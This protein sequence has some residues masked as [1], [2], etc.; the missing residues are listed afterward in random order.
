MLDT[1]NPLTESH[2]DLKPGCVLTERSGAHVGCMRPG[3]GLQLK[4]PFT[5]ER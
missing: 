3:F 2:G 5:W 1:L 4:F